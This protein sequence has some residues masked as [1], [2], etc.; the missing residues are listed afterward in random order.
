MNKTKIAVFALAV[1][2]IAPMS[3]AFAADEAKSGAAAAM[4]REIPSATTEAGAVSEADNAAKTAMDGQDKDGV[5][6]GKHTSEK[7]HE[8]KRH[9]V[10]QEGKDTEMKGGGAAPQEGSKPDTAVPVESPKGGVSED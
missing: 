9:R 2:L 3:G 8:K 6:T 5:K 1:S 10:H 7:K 4:T